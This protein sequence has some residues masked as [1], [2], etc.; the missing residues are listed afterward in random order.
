MNFK[1]FL[2]LPLF[3]IFNIVLSQNNST[4]VKISGKISENLYFKNIYIEKMGKKTIKLASSPIDEQGNFSLNFNVEK[5][6]YHRLVLGKKV[7]QLLVISPGEKID[8]SF[9]L[10]DL[11]NSMVLSGSPVSEIIV[12]TQ[13]I[14]NNFKKR[15]DSLDIIYKKYVTEQNIDSLKYELTLKAQKI[16][17]ER[18]S[19]LHNFILQNNT[20]LAGLIFIEQLNLEQHLNTYGILAKGLYEKYADDDYV[21]SFHNKVSAAQRTAIG[22]PAPEIN[23]PSPSGEKIALSSLLGNVVIIDFW[24]SWCGPCRRENPNKVA[25]YNKYK[26]K[27]VEF[28]SVSLDKDRNAWIAAIENDKLTW[29][30]VSDLKYFQ[31]K[32]AVLYGVTAVPTMFVMNK[33]GFLAAKGLR[34]QQ[35]EAKVIELISQGN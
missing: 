11:Q 23:L 26:D 30:H 21:I 1:I 14:V 3:F 4:S 25:I 8:I 12:E 31:S 19:F 13:K 29:T 9:S 6:A 24:A 34:G 7:Y 15:T 27:G 2:I 28:Y 22:S 16:E 33:K 32:A 35:L 20:S 18:V 17:I 5:T 10:K